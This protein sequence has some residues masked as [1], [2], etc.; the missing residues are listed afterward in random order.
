MDLTGKSFKDNTKTVLASLNPGRR[1][2]TLNVGLFFLKI[3]QISYQLMK[4]VY[5]MESFTQSLLQK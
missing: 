3:S 4:S 1:N 2:N 5:P